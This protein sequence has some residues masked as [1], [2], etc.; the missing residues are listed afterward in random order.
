MQTGSGRGSA[1][2]VAACVL[3]AIER[4]VAEHHQVMKFP[5]QVMPFLR[6]LVGA[7]TLELL[8]TV[9]YF[10]HPPAKLLQFIH[11]RLDATGSQAQFLYQ[12]QGLSATADKMGSGPFSH[13]H[14]RGMA[15]LGHFHGGLILHRV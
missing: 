15:N 3:G 6:R 1:D 11:Q 12:L 14:F 10:P 5:P 7:S 8:D 2:G 9:M 13:A 4:A